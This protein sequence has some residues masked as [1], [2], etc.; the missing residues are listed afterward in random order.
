MAITNFIPTVWSTTLYKELDKTYVGVKLCNRE[1][2]GEIKSAGDTV[3][4]NGLGPVAVGDYV[5]NTDITGPET[6]SDNTRSLTITQAK[7]FNFQLD[8]IDRAQQKPKVMQEAMRNA[9]DALADAA[10]QFIYTLTDPAVSVMNETAVTSTNIIGVLSTA[11]KM[12]MKNNVRNSTKISLEV[13][14]DIEEKLVLA[15]VLRD[16][17]NSKAISKG[18]LG[19]FLGFDIYVSNNI[20]ESEGSFK[21]I[22][23]TGRAITFAEQINDV[24]AYRPESR[25]ADAVK[26]LHLYGA[27]IIYP[28]E[29]LFLNLK[30]AAET[31]V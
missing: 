18:F 22:A 30:P 19:T 5:K 6:L 31:L 20:P 25:F 3:K 4:I 16:T 10:D 11:R 2:E 23:R 14:P 27:K 17:D 29:M 28:K 26:G 21:C 15:K 9:S 8:D 24:E 13:S 12:M 7:F 1:F